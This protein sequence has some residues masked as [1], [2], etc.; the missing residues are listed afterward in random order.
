[1]PFGDGA[2]RS[3][4]D[5]PAV[6]ADLTGAQVP[7]VNRA[8]IG[9]FHLNVPEPFSTPDLI[10]DMAIDAVSLAR[11]FLRVAE[12]LGQTPIPLDTAVDADETR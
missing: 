12:T 7:G 4:S 8:R 1:L 2:Q 3:S 6:A 5:C 9:T 11:P 10:R